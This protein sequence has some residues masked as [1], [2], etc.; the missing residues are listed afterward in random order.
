MDRHELNRMFDA[1]ASAPGREEELLDGLL[2]DVKRR[3]NSM[4]SWKQVADFLPQYF[5]SMTA[6]LN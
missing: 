2:Q 4:K 1:L 3:K 6:Y 5:P